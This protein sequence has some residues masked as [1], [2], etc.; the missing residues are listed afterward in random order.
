MCSD[1]LAVL[2]GTLSPSLSLFWRLSVTQS[3]SGCFGGKKTRLCVSYIEPC[4]RDLAT[5]HQVTRLTALHRHL[6]YDKQTLKSHR[7]YDPFV[8]IY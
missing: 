3:L 4:F 1:T 6:A 7:D 5:D 2:P 8:D